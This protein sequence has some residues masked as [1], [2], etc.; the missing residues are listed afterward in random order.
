MPFY[1]IGE[2]TCDTCS[3]KTSH[4]LECM[5]CGDRIEICMA[6]AAQL[7]GSTRSFGTHVLCHPCQES[8]DKES[9]R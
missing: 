1:T 4:Y 3:R 2:N 8:Y 9:L 6:C 5:K 7:R